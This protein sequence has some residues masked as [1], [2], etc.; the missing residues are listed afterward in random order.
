ML[1]QSNLILH[2]SLLYLLGDYC[3]S[4][5]WLRKASKV[6]CGSAFFILRTYG[7]RSGKIIT[8]RYRLTI[9]SKKIGQSEFLLIPISALVDLLMRKRPV[10]LEPRWK[11]Q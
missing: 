9:E 5:E 8:R 7:F 4:L 1:I 10:K 2:H 6:L 11:L 3:G